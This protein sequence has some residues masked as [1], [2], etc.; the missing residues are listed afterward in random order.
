MKHIG[1]EEEKVQKELRQQQ[2]FGST[3]DYILKSLKQLIIV[4]EKQEPH[5]E[6]GNDPM[7]RRHIPVVVNHLYN[8]LFKTKT[9][10]NSD[11]N[12]VNLGYYNVFT[13]LIDLENQI[14]SILNKSNEPKES[15]E[16][17]LQQLNTCLRA[18]ELYRSNRLRPREDR[19]EHK[20]VINQEK[21]NELAIWEIIKVYDKLEEIATE[22]GPY[23]FPRPSECVVLKRV[24]K[25]IINLEIPP[26]LK[27]NNSLSLI[28][29]KTKELTWTLGDFKMI[30][31]DVNEESRKLQ[32]TIFNMLNYILSKR[33][34]ILS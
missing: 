26:N 5:F 20:P 19:E 12:L 8:E 15:N 16:K 3:V 7:F 28:I 6:L 11:Q 25:T 17:V 2:E 32:R 18:L 1:K 34:D 21:A 30:S 14:E 31:T 24:L 29:E 4:V 27:N 9:L 23:K 33:N 13:A 10:I 22:F